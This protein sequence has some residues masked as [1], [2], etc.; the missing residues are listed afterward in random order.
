M[1]PRLPIPIRRL[2]WRPPLGRFPAWFPDRVLQVLSSAALPG[3]GV[4]AHRQCQSVRKQRVGLVPPC[5]R[6]CPTLKLAAIFLDV[7][8]GHRAALKEALDAELALN[9]ERIF[10]REAADDARATVR[11]WHEGEIHELAEA[12]CLRIVRRFLGRLL[13]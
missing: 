13:T 10:R 8:L 9:A 6:G 12:D 4:A 11:I 7:P 1:R 2:E 5:S 3:S